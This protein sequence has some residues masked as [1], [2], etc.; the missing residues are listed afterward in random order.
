MKKLL[1]VIIATLLMGCGASKKV[2][3]RQTM[4]VDSVA[5]TKTV[6]VETFKSLD[7]TRNEWRKVTITEIEFFTPDS[8]PPQATPN[9]E[10]ASPIVSGALKSIKQSVVET[11]I[12]QN[13]KSEDSQKQ[14]QCKSNANVSKETQIT[15]SATVTQK[16]FPWVRCVALL[17]LAALLYLKRVPIL[18][19]IKK[20]LSGIRRVF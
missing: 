16:P 10:R 3:E 13:G 7:T 20:I 15:K 4:S 2:V 19:I 17:C 12:K 6:N 18:N 14:M 9:K 5:E 1:F 11:G 8:I